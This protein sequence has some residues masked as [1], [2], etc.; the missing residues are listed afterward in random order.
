MSLKYIVTNGNEYLIVGNKTKKTT[1]IKK[2]T[3][4][5]YE[6]AI[7]FLTKNLNNDIRWA[8]RKVN[9]NP[10][11]KN[12]VITN[13]CNYASED[14]G[15]TF[16]FRDAK[17]FNSEADALR[18]VDARGGFFDK[19]YIITEDSSVVNLEEKRQ[20]TKEQLAEIG[21]SVKTKRITFPPETREFIYKKTDCRC[22]ICGKKVK[23]KDFTVDH[24]MPLDRGGTNNVDNLQPTCKQCNT[25]KANSTDK[26]FMRSI[27][28]TLSYRIKHDED[29]TEIIDQ[30]IG[31]CV[32]Q[33]L[34]KMFGE[35][36][37]NTVMM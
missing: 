37:A 13:G 31:S 17:R 22:G 18:Y 6:S 19:V 8:Y 16:K 7:N 5:R 14:G 10:S 26:E 2:A 32:Q 29:N 4:F 24:I 30:L 33:Y 36:V 3:L 11:G 12:Y 28:N 21:V 34:T 35:E 23:Y 27:A 1:N 25:L 15:I 9:N 20:F